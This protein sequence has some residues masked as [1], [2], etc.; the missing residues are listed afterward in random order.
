M[1]LNILVPVHK[2]LDPLFDG[3]LWCIPIGVFGMRDI[4]KGLFDVAGLGGKCVDFGFGVD[5][6]VDGLFSKAH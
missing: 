3:E 2:F 1:R 6:D 5:V 4:G